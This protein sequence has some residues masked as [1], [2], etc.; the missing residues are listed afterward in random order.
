MPKPIVFISFDLN[1]DEAERA[2]FIEQIGGCSVPFTV[3]D[4]SQPP[5]QPQKDW[6]SL[7]RGKIDRASVMII[8][9]G[10]ETQSSAVVARE[11]QFAKSTN[12]PYFG[13]HIGENDSEH[14]LPPGL[15]GNRT[16]PYDWNLIGSAIQQLLKEGKHHVFR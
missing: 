16:I 4:W 10:S 1:R 8:L 3:E 15:T 6:D 12:V 11:I 7:Q 9:V 14:K 2:R 13:V 5:Q